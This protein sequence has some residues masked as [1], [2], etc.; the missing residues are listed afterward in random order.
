MKKDKWLVIGQMKDLQTGV[1]IV[2]SLEEIGHECKFVDS[3]AIVA[4]HGVHGGQ[5]HILK[6]IEE[7]NYVPT[8]IMVLKGLEL[9]EPTITAIKEKFE[10]AIL[11]NW[12]FDVQIGGTDIW[13]NEQYLPVLKMYDYFFCSLEGVADILRGN[14]FDNV[15]HVGEACYPQ[16]HKEVYCNNFQKTKY[17][18]DV[19]FVGSI[20]IDFHKDRLKYLSKIVKEGFNIKIWGEPVGEQKKIPSQVRSKMM[21]VPVINEL[22]S[23]VCQNSLVNLG[24]DGRPDL[25]RS[26]SAR[27]YRI[28]CAGG[29]Y[30]STATKGIEKDF[31]VNAKDKEVT[32]EQEAVVFYDEAD[33]VRKIDFLLEHESIRETIA[34]NGQKKVLAEHTFVHRLK[35]IIEVIKK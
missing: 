13:K 23:V 15:Y 31:K 1:Y 19:A 3:R 21:G 17:G 24:V 27:I 20:G 32:A 30:L 8:H 9:S 22:H 7:L 26:M 2:N 11:T 33:L 6:A 10:K 5:E 12:F 16:A 4:E 29:L 28:M 18:E 25:E 34:K 14:G 35:D